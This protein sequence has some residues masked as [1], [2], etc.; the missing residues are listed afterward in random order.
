MSNAYDPT[1]TWPC[2][3][4]WQGK[5]DNRKPHPQAVEALAYIHEHK[6]IRGTYKGNAHE[7]ATRLPNAL[8]RHLPNVP[9]LSGPGTRKMI[10]EW[11]AAVRGVKAPAQDAPATVAVDAGTFAAFEAWQAAQGS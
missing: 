1:R 7:K 5:G 6:I 10:A 9:N 8:R 3:S 11:Q 2:K 4:L